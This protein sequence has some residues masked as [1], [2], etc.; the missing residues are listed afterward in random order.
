MK[1]FAVF[2]ATTHGPIRVE[3]ITRE[4]APQSMVCLKRSSSIL[5]ISAAYDNF[6]R[7]GSGV[8]ER[9]FGPFE[10]GAF[11]LDLSAAIE[12]GESWQLGFFVAHAIAA[13]SNAELSSEDNADAIIWLTGRVDYDL[14]VGAINHISEKTF[15]SRAAIGKWL[16]AKRPVTLFVPSGADSETAAGAG[17]P[18]GAR[19]IS[20]SSAEDVLS[21]L[22]LSAPR[23]PQ[24]HVP[25]VIPHRPLAARWAAAGIGAVAVMTSAFVL[26]QPPS[27]PMGH[28]IGPIEAA[29]VVASVK[30]GNQPTAPPTASKLALYELRAPADHTCADVQFGAIPPIETAIPATGEMTA[31]TVVGLCSLG[32]SVDNGA[33]NRFVNVNVDVISGKLLYG[34]VK[35]EAFAGQLPFTGRRVWA[36]DVPRR[37]TTPFELRVTATTRPLAQ[38]AAYDPAKS[39][40][41]ATLHHRVLP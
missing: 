19:L 21:V 26:M 38:T 35:P 1:R 36:I 28:I 15:A 20:A 39:V 34:T 8:V 17:I 23:K 25:V 16:S 30:R 24:P 29:P 31:N 33:E 9:A 14:A 10:D 7:P 27:K 40:A 2:I 5:P 37:L 41:T 4:R 12:T 11:R 3:R 18:S 6:V 32:V 22:G 13:S